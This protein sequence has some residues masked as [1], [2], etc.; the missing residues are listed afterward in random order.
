MAQVKQEPESSN[1]INKDLKTHNRLGEK[2]KLILVSLESK[3]EDGMHERRLSLIT[4][5]D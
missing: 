5:T 4:N 2:K 3:V 1:K